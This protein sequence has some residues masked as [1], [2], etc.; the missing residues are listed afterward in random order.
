MAQRLPIAFQEHLQ[1]Q[2]L[3]INAASISF[4]TLT[5][6]SDKFI[7]VREKVGETNQVV[8]IDMADTGNLIRRPITADSAI[9][10]PVSKI[11][12]LKA[13][14]NLQIFNIELKAKVKAHVMHEDVS[15]WRWINT[16]TL[17]LVTDTAVYHWSIEGE[18]PPHKV[19]D[20]HA[21]LTG[22]QIINYRVDPDD[23]WCVLVGISAAQGRVV[24]AMQLY[25]K[26]RGVSQPIEG[27]AGA[28]AEIKMEGATLP[29]KL[30]TF[31]VRNATGAKLHIVEIDHKDGQ[32]V[33]QKKA[34]DIPFA[35]EAAA[36]FPVAMQVSAKY[37][38][39]FMITKFGFVHI[40][41]LESGIEIYRNRVSGDTIFVT[42]EHEQTGG[43]IGVNRKGQVLSVRID[44]QNIIPFILTTLNN[45][46]LAL[47]LASRCNLPG[48]EDLYVA[49]FN[50]IFASGNFSEAA[51][52]AAK[53][54]RGI[55]RTPQTIEHF[56]QCP[57]PPGQMSPILQYFATLLE[58]DK[59]NKIE[60]LELARPVLMQGRKQLLEKWLK[61][62]KLTCTEELGDIVKAHDPTLAL[63]V[64]LRANVPNKVIECFAQT[65]QYNKIIL[66]ANK[67]GFTPD[68]LYLLQTIMRTDPEK[69][70]EFASMLINNE[71][72]ALVTIEQIV[73]VFM[74]MNMIQ[75]ATAFLLDVLKE[76][77]PEQAHLQTRLLEMNLLAAPQVADA[78]LGNEMFTHYDKAHIAQLCEK[79]GLFQR[80]LEHYTD[81]YDIKR[82][83]VHTHLLNPEW[84]VNY[85]GRLSVE[86]S[87]ECMR[88]MLNTNLRQ[89]LQICVQIATKY[90]ELLTPQALIALFESYKTFEGLYYFLGSIVNFS[91]DADVH[92]KYIQAACRTGQLKEVE[93]IC[94]ESN[95]YD[96]EKVKNFLKEAK[97]TDQL[98]LIIVCDR[99]DFVH[100]LVLYL[101]QNN[102]HKY[103]EIYVQKVNPSRT[104]AVIG[105]LLDVDCEENVIKS[106][107][108][109]VRGQ[110]PI[111]QLV[112]E[113]EKRNRLKLLLPWFEMKMKEGSQDPAVY[114]AL[115][116][117]YIDSNNNA[118]TFLKENKLYDPRVIGKYCEKRDPYLAFIAYQQGQCDFELIN[119]TN[120]NSMFK[121]QARYLVKRRDT[122]LWAH[123]L[124]PEN[125][126]MR[127]L[128]DQVV[129]TALPETQDPEDVS[130]T[131]K[132]FMSA[133]L[134]NE[135]MELLEKIVLENSAF[136]D[137]RNLQN[138]LILTA[139]QADKSKVMDY[140]NRLNNYDAPEIAK[141]AIKGEL[142]E[143]AFTIFKKYDVH[144]QAVEVLVNNIGNIDRAYEYAEKVDQPEVWSILAKAQL[145]D[146]RIK[147]AIDSYIK[148]NDHS[149]WIDVINISS[150]AGKFEDL[151]RYLQMARKKVR[152]A[153]VESELIFAFAKTNRLAELEEFISAPNIAQIQVVGDRCFNEQLYEAAKI[154]FN[155]ISNWARLA[156]TLVHL[157]EFQAA[158]DCA[159]KANSTK[160]WKEIHAACVE[161]KEFR[162]A[163]ICGLNLVIHAEELEEL[164]RLYE[165][166]GYFD[167][168]M[169][170]LEASLNLERAHMGMFTEL[171]ILYSKYRPERLM[172][173]LKLF[174]SR[175]NIPKVIRACEAAHL[176]TELVFLYVHYDEFDNAALTMM[177]YS[178]DAWEHNSFKDIIVKVS[179]L[180]IYYKALRFYLDEQ[181]MQICD[182]L[183][184]LTPRIDHTRVV[185]MFEK[186][187]NIP[188]IKNYLIAV[189]QT[190]NQAVNTAYNDLLIEEEDYKS[191]RASIDHY[192]NFDNIALALR[193][194]KHELLEFRRIA[195]HLYKKNKRWKQSVALSKKDK[196]FKD[197]METAAESRDTETAEDLLQY[198]IDNNNKECFAACLFTCY[199]L[200]RPDVVMEIAWKNGLTDMAM[201][202]M[203]QVMREY[204]SKVDQLEKANQERSKK[205]EEKE[206][207]EYNMPMMAPTM[208]APLMITAGPSSMAPPMGMGQ[209]PM[210]M[211]MGMGYGNVNGYQGY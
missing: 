78:I 49:K 203:I 116:K 74:S 38:I 63:S 76:N 69:G 162:L 145:N 142:F 31:A 48:A 132:A 55:L 204:T 123:V 202:Y 4:A 44:E 37:G 155:S 32:P 120:E 1:L 141:I 137:N 106:L 118:E 11:I 185:Q 35:P 7:C 129:A 173:H 115:A 29:T 10:H 211:G 72:G 160:V 102:L 166:H 138:L 13:G 6:E 42:T 135:L 64:Y 201:P 61:E 159:R 188:L 43:F 88:E 136:S 98:P 140:V 164:I 50:Q 134:P 177:K 3:G 71:G 9:M 165:R 150:R 100:D 23:K 191:L 104:P 33:Y 57:V 54:P 200:L 15:Y 156:S 28:F 127:A 189:Q 197:A 5:M 65:G 208:H 190:N 194:E 20:R 130:S 131:V 108:G 143:E 52:M 99:F 96:A 40:Y 87:L 195:A 92:F 158:V 101:Y 45:T 70:T 148:A 95:V 25:H 147:E 47:R 110:I 84:V 85:F 94:R 139:I 172:D 66:Y 210:G 51:K 59:L 16:S 184:A 167:E 111:D 128:I 168:L 205:E 117:I 60:S 206:K 89:N 153:M 133:D 2:A 58:T 169:A 8:I 56:K 22:S 18:T 86:Q 171:S 41:D 21:S 119:I 83:I 152:E 17:G 183:T 67:V 82:T 125:Q 112:E 161:Q 39:V 53:S 193:L 68:Y 73:D 26:E 187:D 114:N 46:D 163:Q 103:I 151:I 107:L 19:F 79:A 149:N 178:A 154:L 126:Y 62:D 146:L 176:W 199:D 12:A 80:A 36:D 198:F 174:W 122:A 181:P 27:H 90:A 124:S 180:E 157:K 175:I 179:N 144:A 196:L 105:A 170:L 109:S 14:R 121:H 34:V 91:Q 113:T 93:R 182:L 209:A 30:F 186:S 207:Q 192:D 81:I 77:K 24:G 97:L 75:Q